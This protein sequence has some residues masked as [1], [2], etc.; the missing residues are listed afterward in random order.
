MTHF[1]FLCVH[2]SW[3]TK[4]I[5]VNKHFCGRVP[6]FRVNLQSVSLSVFTFLSQNDFVELPEKGHKHTAQVEGELTS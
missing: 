1:M 6:D 2:W 4:S 3:L 5:I